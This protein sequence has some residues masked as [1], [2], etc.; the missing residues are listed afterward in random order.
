MTLGLERRYKTTCTTIG[1]LLLGHLLALC[2]CQI[3]G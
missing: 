1:Y 3:G 2:P